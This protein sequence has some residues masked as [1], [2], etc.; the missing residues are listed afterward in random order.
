MRIACP[1]CNAAYQVPDDQLREGRVVRCARCGTDW[2]PLEAVPADEGE[3]EPPLPPPSIEVPA[4]E[5]VFEP[6]TMPVEEEE[7]PI[8]RPVMMP[9]APPKPRPPVLLMFAWVVSLAVVAAGVGGLY[10]RRDRVMQVWPPSIR[11][12]G[13][14]GLASKPA[15]AEPPAQAG[16]S[17]GRE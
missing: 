8:P 13:P 1:A 10:V 5:P 2:S 7:I 15:A 16:A 6:E 3:R 9:K 4:P 14:L 11:A 17:E 12:Y